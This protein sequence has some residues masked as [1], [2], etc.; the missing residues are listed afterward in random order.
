M[1]VL[2]Y[3]EKD[4]NCSLSAA[5]LCNCIISVSLKMDTFSTMAFIFTVVFAGFSLSD[6]WQSHK[7]S[8]NIS[9]AD[10]IYAAFNVSCCKHKKYQKTGCVDD[11]LTLGVGYNKVPEAKTIQ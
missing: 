11:S 7:S 2:Y 3:K 1:C 8:V 6:N 4:R 5:V 10:G 9:T